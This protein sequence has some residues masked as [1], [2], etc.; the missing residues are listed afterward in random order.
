MNT[1]KLAGSMIFSVLIFSLPLY[2]QADLG[3]SWDS[4]KI[5]G[6]GYITGMKVHPNNPDVIYLRTDVGGAYRWN[7]AEQEMEQIVNLRNEN[8]Q[9]VAGIALHPGN[10]DLVYLAVDRQNDAANSA[11]LKST[12]RGTTWT[13]IPTD[14]FKFGANGGRVN[15]DSEDRDREGSPIAVNPNDQNELWVGS[16]GRGLWRLNGTTSWTRVAE[17][18]IADNNLEQSVRNIL[19]HP[20]DPNFLYVGHFGQGIYRSSNGG[21][22]FQ[23]I[24]GNTNAVT[25]VS[26]LSFSKNGTKLYAACRNQGVFRLDT[27]TTSTFWTDTNPRDSDINFGFLTVTASPHDDN[28]VLANPASTGGF[29]FPRLLVSYDSGENW[30][31]INN[32]T[33]TS[34]FLWNQG[35]SEGQH[36]SQLTFDPTD[37]N[38]LYYTAFSGIWHTAD[39]QAAEVNWRNDMA[40]GHEEIVNTGLIAYPPNNNGNTI[41]VNSADHAGWTL[42]DLQAFPAQDI[43]DLVTSDGPFIKG[44]GTAVCELQPENIVVSS[45]VNWVGSNGFL[46]ASNNG[47][48]TF[49][50]LSGY[51]PSWGKAVL[52]IAQ[53]DPSNIVAVNQDGIKF[54]TNGGDTFQSATGANGITIANNVFFRFRPLTA[55]AGTNNTFYLYDRSSGQIHR[56]INSGQSWTQRGTIT[57]F[58]LSNE[59]GQSTRLLSAFGQTGHLW[60]NHHSQGI[61]RSTN[62]GTTWT[63]IPDVTNAIAMAIGKE[64]SAGD[65]A[66]LYFYGRLSGDNEDWF[67][68]STNEGASWDRV[69]HES[70]LFVGT[71]ARHLAADRDEFGKFYVGTSGFGVWS[72]T[73]VAPSV[74]LGDVNRDGFVD[75]SDISPFIVLI[76]NGNFQAE[77]D[78]NQDGAINF[79]DISPFIALLTGV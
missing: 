65:Y 72:A 26:D 62:G 35:D 47:G 13:E 70:N 74:T 58:T 16:R 18:T 73:A 11:I 4:V 30:A 34:S 2:G 24:N 31:R 59:S 38:K 12:D 78:T 22:T 61:R 39:F 19:Y 53:N 63:A 33:I 45:T 28:L 17:A 76:T 29:N 79:L 69:F 77:A 15:T 40:S 20:T 43:R 25:D 5:G 41:G 57:N 44:A 9:G 68:R 75:F 46:L 64:E 27:P 14:N 67:Y 1:I 8:Y 32:V 21:Q 37:P 50:P 52:A 48:Q 42:G 36:C 49:N 54:S 23:L 51:T 71:A 6:G 60:I 56:S 55:D 10:E 66:T 7:A 3:Y